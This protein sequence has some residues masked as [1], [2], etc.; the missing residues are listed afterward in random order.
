MET[1]IE[2]L[3]TLEG[4]RA[5]L[6][7]PRTKFTETAFKRKRKQSVKDAESWFSMEIR[8]FFAANG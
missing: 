5:A 1:D 2:G 8:N 3:A 4:W 6:K 7:E